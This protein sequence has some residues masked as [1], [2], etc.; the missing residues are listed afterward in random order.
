MFSE[1]I[2][3]DKKTRWVLCRSV[4]G[5]IW[6]APCWSLDRMQVYCSRVHFLFRPTL[7]TEER[8][9]CRTFRQIVN[10]SVQHHEILLPPLSQFV[11]HC[12]HSLLLSISYHLFLCLSLM[13]LFNLHSR[14]STLLVGDHECVTLLTHQEAELGEKDTRDSPILNIL[15]GRDPSHDPIVCPP[16]LILH[17]SL[18]HFLSQ[19]PWWLLFPLSLMGITAE[20]LISAPLNAD[21]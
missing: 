20:V 7:F 4:F 18:S 17:F 2:S 15:K 13:S 19:G 8:K 16:P 21:F 6:A 10:T 12:V 3:L 14:T 11:V 5:T 1:V 9:E